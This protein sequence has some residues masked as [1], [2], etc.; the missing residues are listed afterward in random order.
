FFPAVDGLLQARATAIASL[1][2]LWRNLR[3]DF[4]D[5]ARAEI[6]RRFAE[7]NAQSF[8][9]L[10][11]KLHRALTS[12]GGTTL[13]SALRNRY[14]YALIDEFQDT[15]PLQWGIFSA[16]YSGADPEHHAAFLVGDPKQAIYSFRN[17]DVYAYLGAIA[18]RGEPLRL[19]ESQ[20]SVPGLV[21]ALNALFTT[22]PDPFRLDAIRYEEVTASTREKPPLVEGRP[23][24]K[25][26][27][28][29][30]IAFHAGKADGTCAN[31]DVGRGWAID[32]TADEIVRLLDEAAQGHASLGDRALEAGDIAVLVNTN[33]QATQV[34]D[35]LAE[36]GIAA[37]EQ[38]T[39]TVFWSAEAEQLERLLFAVT[40]PKDPG[41][42]RSALA[43]DLVGLGAARIIE[44]ADD[45]AWEAVLEEFDH[46]HET[47]KAHGLMRMLREL[48]RKRQVPEQLAAYRDGERRLTNLYHV[49]ELLHLEAPHLAGM[50][51]VVA[52]LATR[53]LD[54][55]AATTEDV[56]LRLESDA[57]LVQI[58]TVHKSKGL[59]YPVTF[60]PFLWDASSRAGEG[61]VALYH[62][63]DPPFRLRLDAGSDGYDAALAV[64]R[65]EELAERL[66]VAYVALTRA[67]N[68]CYVFTGALSGIGHSA[69][70]WLVHGVDGA[71]KE[72]DVPVAS[73]LRADLDGLIAKSQGTIALHET[74]AGGAPPLA[75]VGARVAFTARTP[76]R[77]MADG[78][79]LTSF[80]ALHAS[81]GRQEIEP[82]PDHDESDGV[83]AAEAVTQP[84]PVGGERFSFP[85]GTDAGSCLHAILER[86]DFAADDW[87]PVIREQLSRSGYQSSSPAQVQEWLREVLRVPLPA[88][89]GGAPFALGAVAKDAQF[90]ELPF[91]LA[92][93][94]FSPRK[95]V[96]IAK[97]YGVAVPEL[98]SRELRGYLNGYIDLVFRHDGRWYVADHKSNWLGATGDGYDR[99]GIAAAMS[100]GHY[101]L[102]YLIY[103][104]A[105][106]RWL[107]GAV[108]GY[109]YDREFGG[110]LY[111]FLR[112]MH[113]DWRDAAGA[114]H[115]VFA[116]RPPRALIEA[117]DEAF[118]CTKSTGVV[119]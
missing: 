35:A 114:P 33:K 85:R 99:D 38:S 19:L 87:L 119:A 37:A 108:Q 51:A 8:D 39:Q 13:A 47:W 32:A 84:G 95:I 105:V 115:G 117:L 113:P 16:I 18:D 12:D 7:R 2:V 81:L 71:Q 62:A 52:Y 14:R 68:R 96:A 6:A 75:L 23:K 40:S 74:G 56:Q 17:A 83:D 112:G 94:G 91:Q 26:R 25:D 55:S 111:L 65:E 78:L 98:P 82:T 60:V 106:H 53:R 61:D 88:P 63:P 59:E 97:A 64:A 11:Q 110:V 79:T 46:Y 15:D 50:D 20:R 45:T 42:L 36:R 21:A 9:D 92:F 66:R 73:Q 22:S 118:G 57:H 86:I 1:T 107:R 30:R 28:P 48:F 43:T 4:A 27:A 116:S 93:D 101:H 104:T 67:K 76:A 54:P 5:Y 34:R 109:D 100:G 41:A 89:A 58:V 10:L 72:P 24:G 90:R 70:G 49:C 69:L 31:K 77:A 102:Q 29:L 44:L 103:V 3:L 80:S